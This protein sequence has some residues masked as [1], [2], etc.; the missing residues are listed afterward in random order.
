MVLPGGKCEPGETTH[1]GMVRELREETGLIAMSARF[2]YAAPSPAESRR[3]VHLFYI[4]RWYHQGGDSKFK[5]EPGSKV[6]WT[7]WSNLVIRS[8]FKRF[9]QATVIA[10]EGNSWVVNESPTHMAEVAEAARQAK[11]G[12]FQ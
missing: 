4:N 2:V 5:A 7:T 10:L 6:E 9:Y 8:P 3:V 1:E 11:A 12:F